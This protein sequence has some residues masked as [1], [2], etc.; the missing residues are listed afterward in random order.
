MFSGGSCLFF[1]GYSGGGA[2]QN[3]NSR[4]NET[5]ALLHELK[6]SLWIDRATR[7]V[8]VDFSVYNA[9]LNLFCI[10]KLIF[11][12]PATGGIIPSNEFQTVKLIR[13]DGSG[14]RLKSI[15]NQ[16]SLDMLIQQ[17]M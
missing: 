9:N 11:E 15:Q 14:R 12:F 3:L 17:T 6:E 4:K 13:S 10:I 2:I 1:Q 7:V 5:K 8:F 16:M